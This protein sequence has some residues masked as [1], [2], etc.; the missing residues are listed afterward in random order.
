MAKRLTTPE[1]IDKS[2]AI[3]GDRYC[4]SKSVYV[5]SSEKVTIICREHDEFFQAPNKHLLGRGC[6]ICAGNQPETTKSFTKKAVAV[7][8]DLYDYSLVEYKGNKKHVTII[9]CKHGEF[10]QAPSDH[11]N[12]KSGCPKCK[13]EKIGDIRRFT[14]SQFIAQANE[15]HDEKYNYSKVTYVTSDLK[16]V[17]TCCRHGDFEQQ[18]NSHLRGAGCPDCGNDR[19]GDKCRKTLSEFIFDAQ[20]MHGDTYLYQNSEYV[21]AKTPVI[22]TCQKHGDFPQN[23]SRHTAG[24]GCQLCANEASSAKQRK[25]TAKFIV[26]AVA[27]HGDRY[28]YG[29]VE[30]TTDRGKVDIVCREHGLFAQIAGVHLAG[31]GCNACGRKSMLEKQ[32]KTT[33]QFVA[34]AIKK[35]GT[36]YD[37]SL[38]KYVGA[39]EE[40]EIICHSHGAFM[41]RP[42]LHTG[43]SGCQKCGYE[44]ASKVMN[45]G[46]DEFIARSIASH[47]HIYSYDNVTYANSVAEVNIWCDKHGSFMQRPALHMNGAGCP[48]C[49]TE[50]RA[51]ESTMTTAEFLGRA[52]E[53]HGDRYDYSLAYY[54]TAKEKVKLIC[55][56]HGT[57]EQLPTS[58][59]G[60]AGCPRCASDVIGSYTR[61]STAEFISE[62]ISMHG[63]RY[64]YDLAEYK[65]AHHKVRIIC[66]KHG[67]FSQAARVHTDGGGC[68]KC[69]YGC[70]K[71]TYDASYF[72][73]HPKSAD[74]PCDLYYIEFKKDDRSLFK[75]GI[76]STGKRWPS[77]YKGWVIREIFRK[78]MTKYQCWEEECRVLEANKSRRY[79][80]KDDEFIGNGWTEMFTFD[81][82]G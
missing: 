62:A 61:K 17:I 23:P 69:N 19:I 72:V 27:K 76:D 16:V 34:E 80:V 77:T 82:F 20:K 31:G 78:R 15:V 52:R 8:G 63:D 30:Y 45:L 7:H 25:T 54:L 68:P 48:K 79:R 1:F 51:K 81:I 64:G 53:T 70:G 4:Y 11:T 60:G 41:Q 24:A 2:T 58:H 38:S 33:E 42:T 22:I 43:G 47:G 66:S 55:D 13:F 3:H 56:K 18:A 75:I 57:F 59:L 10:K 40:I 35:H 29:S 14:Q 32:T 49:S 36:K 65:N 71:G 9:C 67:E 44:S 50:R 5:R 39:N 21:D 26:E 37:Y 74:E 73:R 6:P 28:E 46:L 12:Q